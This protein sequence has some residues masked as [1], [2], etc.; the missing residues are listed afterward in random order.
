MKGFQHKQFRVTVEILCYATDIG[1]PLDHL[2]LI[3]WAQNLEGHKPVD[4]WFLDMIRILQEDD[5]D[6][7]VS[8]Y[9]L[10]K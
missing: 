2:D 5:I 4:A 1:L 8:P 7:M 3:S 6:E 10:R 9:Q